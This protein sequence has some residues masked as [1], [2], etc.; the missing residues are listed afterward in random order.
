V[1]STVSIIVG[2]VLVMCVFDLTVPIVFG[3]MIE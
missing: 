2:K 3:K 1:Y